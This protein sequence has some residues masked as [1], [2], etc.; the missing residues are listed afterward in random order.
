LLYNIYK[1]YFIQLDAEWDETITQAAIITSQ[2]NSGFSERRGR[3]R[4]GRGGFTNRPRPTEGG[5]RFGE[6]RKCW[7]NFLLF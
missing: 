4:G 6:S 3:G 5:Q 2:N 7:C 1:Y